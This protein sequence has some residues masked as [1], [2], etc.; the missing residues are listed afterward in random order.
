MVLEIDFSG[1]ENKNLFVYLYIKN[2][3]NIMYIPTI[4]PC[5]YKYKKDKKKKTKLFLFQNKHFSI[6]ICKNI[7]IKCA[8]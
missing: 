4:D 8:E 1:Q 5:K 2:N 7:I 3:K 6:L